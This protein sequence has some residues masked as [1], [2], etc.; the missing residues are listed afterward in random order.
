MTRRLIGL[1]ATLTVAVLAA[2]CD[3]APPTSPTGPSLVQTAS[4]FACAFTGNPSLSSAINGYF[5]S[6]ADRKT[7]SDLAALLQTAYNT[8]PTPNY[9]GAK[10]PGFNLLVFVG[11]T[12]RKSGAGSSPAAG[13]AVV[14]QTI[15][16]MFDVAANIGTVTTPGAFFGWGDPASAQFDFASALDIS[17]GGTFHVRGGTSDPAKDPAVGNLA[18]A[19]TGSATA[20]GNLSVLSPPQVSPTDTT[21]KTWS[22]ILTNTSRVLIYGNAVEGGYD[23]KLIPR[24]TGFAPSATVALCQG[25]GTSF[26]TT[27]M[28]NQSGVGV[29]GYIDVD[30]LCGTSPIVASTGLR[31]LLLQQFARVGDLLAPAPLSASSALVL[32]TIGGSLSGA[33]GDAFTG[34]SVPAVAL[35][36]TI[37]DPKNPL[38]VN[39][40]NLG[41]ITV[42]VQTPLP[43]PQSPVGGVTVTLAAVN[44]NGFTQVGEIIQGRGCVAPVQ[45]KTTVAT[46]GVGG[47]TAETSVSW[48]NACITKTGVVAITA[49]S[50]AV[51]RD[52]GIG[53]TSSTKFNVKP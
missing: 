43:A 18:D 8:A 53:S 7:A 9:T 48:I 11:Q 44:N 33:K 29:L 21:K 49:T 51:G 28:V 5:T 17:Q 10:D 20:A 39:T 1:T 22:S 12:A 25:L 15:Q 30:Y 16:C 34:T 27:D 4:P 2:A 19:V 50:K 14:R 23:W 37:S 40:G 46:I 3:E 32:S 13:A 35:T 6:S 52:G 45:P 26:T 41:T 42:K 24:N 36:L 31:G 47:I 38:K